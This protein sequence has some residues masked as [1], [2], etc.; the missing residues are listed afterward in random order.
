MPV[1]VVKIDRFFVVDVE[2]DRWQRE[3]MRAVLEFARR[4]GLRTV[5]V[6]VER[7]SQADV[8]RELGCD[9]I[10]GYFVARPAPPD[11]LLGMVLLG[12]APARSQQRAAA[13]PGLNSHFAGHSCS[14]TS[15]KC[16][17]PSQVRK[18][19]SWRVRPS[20]V[21]SRDLQMF[22]HET[23]ESI[24]SQRPDGRTGGRG[25]GA[26]LSGARSRPWR[27]ISGFRRGLKLVDQRS[28]D[29]STSDPAVDQ[30]GNR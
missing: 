6:G 25:S 9:T 27:L 17:K 12:Y 21:T 14:T 29:R 22:V 11:D 19:T 2:H 20:S 1:D 18:N 7:A 30:P 3:F 13:G 28:A 8:L 5:A 24:S 15:R 10:Q 26:C 23:A 16:F 4:L